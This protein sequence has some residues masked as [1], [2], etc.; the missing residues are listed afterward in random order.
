M[1]RVAGG[2]AYRAVRNRGTIGGSLGHADPA[3]DWPA[4]LIALGAEL[5]LQGPRGERVVKSE[6]FVT[7]VLETVLEPAEI[8]ETVRIPRLGTAA[9]FGHQ[10]VACKPGDFADGIA[11]VVADRP[12]A[13]R[14]VIAGPTQP[15][16]RLPRTEAALAAADQWTGAL[17]RDLRGTVAADLREAGRREA[18]D[19]YAFDLH[20]VIAVRAAREAFVP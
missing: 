11:V 4:V 3:A 18:D 17:E 6:A 19:G 9:R 13:V 5:R 7:G 1:R 14:A 2:I 12:K 20:Q 10:K 8:L 16:R 15:P